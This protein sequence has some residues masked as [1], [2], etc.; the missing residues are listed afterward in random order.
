MATSA[1]VHMHVYRYREP[2]LV[3]ARTR[4]CFRY[5]LVHLMAQEVCPLVVRFQCL[6]G[7]FVP[8]MNLAERQLVSRVLPPPIPMTPCGLH[9]P[10]ALIP[11]RNVFSGIMEASKRA[12]NVTGFPQ[13][14][15]Q[16]RRFISA[17]QC[18]TCRACTNV[19]QLVSSPMAGMCF[20]Q[21]SGHVARVVGLSL[22]STLIHLPS[23]CLDP[24]LSGCMRRVDRLHSR[25]TPEEYLWWPRRAITTKF[26]AFNDV[27][28]Q[29]RNRQRQSSVVFLLDVRSVVVGPILTHGAAARPDA[30][31]RPYEYSSVRPLHDFA[32]SASSK[33]CRKRTVY[34]PEYPRPDH[35]ESF[36]GSRPLG[37]PL[38]VSLVHAEKLPYPRMHTERIPSVKSLSCTNTTPGSPPSTLRIYR[39][40]C[41]GGKSPSGSRG[42]V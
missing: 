26:P 10:A 31:E 39:N 1:R 9:V 14:L 8:T 3:S 19:F 22:M 16:R 41:V 15:E 2:C 20:Q 28:V 5:L 35:P 11:F 32:C 18:R 13:P 30:G 33:R 42:W 21:S 6:D 4:P 17:Q 34:A 27:R 38:I 7:L 37:C 12:I 25:A 23:S 40:P 24:A 36:Q 29:R